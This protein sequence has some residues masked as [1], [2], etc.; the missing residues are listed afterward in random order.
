MYMSRIFVSICLVRRLLIY[1]QYISLQKCSWH[2]NVERWQ[3]IDTN[4]PAG[5][6]PTGRAELH[7]FVGMATRKL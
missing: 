5:M 3:A 1:S 4:N 7:K 2:T 6:L